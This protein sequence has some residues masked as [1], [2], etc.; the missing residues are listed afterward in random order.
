MVVVVVALVVVGCGGD[1]ATAA[2]DAVSVAVVDFAVVI[3]VAID[4]VIDCFRR[5]S[6]FTV[7]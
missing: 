7:S 4:D 1:I 3:T 6:L 2:L 5:L